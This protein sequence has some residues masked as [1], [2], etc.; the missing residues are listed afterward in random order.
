MINNILLYAKED[1][2]EFLK[3]KMDDINIS[4]LKS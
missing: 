4:I 2:E 1:S 3:C